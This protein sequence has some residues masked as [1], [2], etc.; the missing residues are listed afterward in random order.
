M[1]SA[2]EKVNLMTGH[3]RMYSILKHP[4]V[5]ITKWTKIYIPNKKKK[6]TKSLPSF[7]LLLLFSFFFHSEGTHRRESFCPSTLMNNVF[8]ILGSFI[9][10]SF[11]LCNQIKQNLKTWRKKRKVLE[12]NIFPRLMNNKLS[13][14]LNTYCLH[15]REYF[16][17]A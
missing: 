12:I 3:L 10:F 4:T 1:L 7:G 5:I 2:Y 17:I 6:K 13:T 16:C 15:W 11:S 8:P 9:L 14:K